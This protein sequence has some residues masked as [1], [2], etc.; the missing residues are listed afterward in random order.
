MTTNFEPEA[1]F[2]SSGTTGSNTSRHF[3]KEL[4]IYRESY[5]KAF[6]RF[7]GDPRN[8]CIVGL[9]PGYLE[10]GNS[11]LVNMVNELIR[12]SEHRLSGFYLNDLDKLY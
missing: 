2:E 12:E 7:Y 4:A 9:L 11:S 3:V 5:L 6:I 10:R 8:W 1:I